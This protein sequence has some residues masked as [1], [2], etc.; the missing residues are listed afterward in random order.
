MIPK[1]NTIKDSQRLV[2]GY[3]THKENARQIYEVTFSDKTFLNRVTEE[4]YSTLV[5]YF[6]NVSGGRYTGLLGPKVG[7]LVFRIRKSNAVEFYMLEEEN[8]KDLDIYEMES[9]LSD[10]NEYAHKMKKE[11]V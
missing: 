5:Q 6:Q 4:A 9:F 2:I 1:Y 10:L 8:H 11:L 3:D 7:E